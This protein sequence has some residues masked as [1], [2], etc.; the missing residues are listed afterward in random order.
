[1]SISLSERAKEHFEVDSFRRIERR[2]TSFLTAVGRWGGKKRCALRNP[3]ALIFKN[4]K[5]PIAFTYFLKTNVDTRDVDRE[6]KR[7]DG[8]HYH[9]LLWR[10]TKDVCVWLVDIQ[11]RPKPKSSSKKTKNTKC[12]FLFFYFLTWRQPKTS[13]NLLNK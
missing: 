10:F 13:E 12:R 1:M 11:N 2:F 3:V 7:N 8:L 4:K 5:G 6:T 9:F